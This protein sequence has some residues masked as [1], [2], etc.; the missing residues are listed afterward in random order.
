MISIGWYSVCNFIAGF[1]P[2]FWFLFLFRAFARHRHGSG[3][4]VRIGGFTPPRCMC[5]RGVEFSAA[6]AK[7]WA[8][9]SRVTAAA[10]MIMAEGFVRS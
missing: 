7:V 2:A 6:L 5:R 1:A 4:A 9:A 3:M 10:P 8:E